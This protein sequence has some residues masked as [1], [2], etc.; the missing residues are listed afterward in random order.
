VLN[1]GV[2]VTLDLINEAD[3]K[4]WAFTFVVQRSIVQLTFSEPM[5]RDSPHLLEFCAGAA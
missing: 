4:T 3:A 1:D 2:E 5:K